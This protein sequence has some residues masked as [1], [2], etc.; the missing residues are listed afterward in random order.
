[1]SPMICYLGFEAASYG[2]A[3]VIADKALILLSILTFIFAI[4]TLLG[5]ILNKYQ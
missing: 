2:F 5:N 1:M 3:R 4:I